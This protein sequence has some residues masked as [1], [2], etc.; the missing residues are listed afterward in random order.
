MQ[1]A[2]LFLNRYLRT[3]S[4]LLKSNGKK[5]ARDS[6][7]KISAIKE[8]EGEFQIGQSVITSNYTTKDKKGTQ[9]G[10]DHEKAQ[11]ERKCLSKIRDREKTKLT[12]RHIYHE[13]IS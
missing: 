1:R 7:K 11:S 12:I 4:D 3:R 5:Q 8:R 2:K 13:N 6:K 10:N 9:V